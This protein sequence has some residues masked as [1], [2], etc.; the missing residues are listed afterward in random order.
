MPTNITFRSELI[1]KL[2]DFSQECGLPLLSNTSILVELVA[3]VAKCKEE[4]VNLQPRVYITNDIDLCNQL[5]GNAE[6]VKIG[7]DEHGVKGV[8]LTI[9]KCA[10]LAVG[11]WSIY[12]HDS[13]GNI[14]YGLFR[15]SSNVTAIPVDDMLFAADNGELDLKVVKIHQITDECVE[16]R[17]GNDK[18][19][20][21]HFN[22]QKG[23]CPPP[24]EY[25]DSLVSQ[26]CAGLAE[27]ERV[28]NF[29]SN[30]LMDGLRKSHGCLIAVTAMKKT[31][32]IL[33]DGVF[34]EEPLDF[35]SLIDEASRNPENFEYLISKSDLVKGM[36]NSDGI[37]LFDNNARLLG[38]N[39]FINISAK[40]SKVVGGARRRA[41]SALKDAV[42]KK[43]IV[44]AFM[45]SQDGWT[46]FKGI[47]SG[48]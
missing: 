25:F 39:C 12:I 37:M 23:S 20:Y 2:H 7:A 30:L 48:E 18:T 36:L 22:H 31:P 42:G 44:A 41:Y 10:P 34:L 6:K 9:K 21:V 40:A 13:D 16:I 14:D 15:G 28:K 27:K 29:L 45:Q 17:S 19:Y 35:S 46:E 32:S 26:I 1:G 33:S 43:G 24:L 4:G 47:D 3:L 5:I 8:Q 11:V 38:Y